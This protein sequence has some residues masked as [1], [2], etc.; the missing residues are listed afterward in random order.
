MPVNISTSGQHLKLQLYRADFQVAYKGI[1]NAPLFTGAAQ[2]EVNRDYL[3]NFYITA[4]PGIN[5]KRRT[6]R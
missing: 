2:Q 3:N 6:E 1:D 4:V 5:E